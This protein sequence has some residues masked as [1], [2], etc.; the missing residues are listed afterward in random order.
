M[1]DA[2]SHLEDAIK[3]W[4]KNRVG[5]NMKFKYTYSSIQYCY[6]NFRMIL[7]VFNSLF[8]EILEFIIVSLKILLH[9]IIEKVVHL[10][11]RNKF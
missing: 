8:R 5:L 6:G 4:W 3:I 11:Y 1:N 9:Y 7:F 10:S 2:D